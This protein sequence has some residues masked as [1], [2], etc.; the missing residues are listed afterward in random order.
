MKTFFMSFRP[1]CMILLLLTLLLGIGYPLCMWGIGQLFFQKEAGG[2]LLFVN[3]KPIGAENIGQNFTSTKY[4]H[5][6]PSAAGP[7]GYDAAHS[8]GSNLG[9]TSKKLIDTLHER[10][11]AFRLINNLSSKAPLPADAITSSASGLDPHI[12]TANALLQAPRVASARGLSEEVIQN[13][14]LEHTE[15]SSWWLAGGDYVNV[16]RLNLALDAREAL[17]HQ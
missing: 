11:D 3:G 17:Q 13:L 15:S 2:S 9:P 1:A 16:L 12:S 6:R 7:H 14:I 4:F 10:A 5:P 8:S